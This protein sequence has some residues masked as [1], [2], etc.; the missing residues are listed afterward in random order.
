MKISS[1]VKQAMAFITGDTN[2]VI[3]QQNFRSADAAVNGQIYAQKAKLVQ[4]EQSLEAA[5]KKLEA[6]KYP[7][8]NITNTEGYINNLVD[9]NNAVEV[10]QEKV[11]MITKAITFFSGLVKEFNE[12]VEA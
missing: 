12:E 10:A 8:S 9:A 7:I 4:A 11:E 6:A 5:K 3:A 2:E 1:Y